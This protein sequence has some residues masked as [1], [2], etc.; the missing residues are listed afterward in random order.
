MSLIIAL[1]V[2]YGFSFTVDQNLIHP[3]IARPRILYVH[4]AVFSGWL[5]FL[6]LQ[7][8][9]IRTRNVRIHKWVGCLG[10]ALGGAILVLGISTS[11]TMAHFNQVYLHLD[12]VESDLIIQFFDMISFTIPFILAI[13]WRKR[14]EFHRRLIFVASCALT[15][16]AFGRFPHQIVPS[17]YFY[18]GVDILIFLG[19]ARDIIVDHYVHLIYILGLPSLIFGQIIVM[20]FSTHELSYWLRVAHIILN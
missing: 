1:V 13:Y 5:F 16:A 19:I 6:I 4:S 7:S 8:G 20:Y 3:S 11:I 15:S 17:G 2:A 14:P 10:V 9:L 12:H 18:V